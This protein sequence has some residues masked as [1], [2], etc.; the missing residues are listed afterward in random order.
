MPSLPLP[1]GPSALTGGV[2]PVTGSADVL[3]EFPRPQ[4][5]A[6]VAPVR[7]A[8]VAAFAAGFVK[9]QN[10]ASRAALQSDPMMATGNY[11]KSFAD[12]HGVIPGV[13]E[14]EAS[15]RSR[16]FTAPEVVTPEFI[17]AGVNALI[18][19]HSPIGCHLSELELD[20]WFVH[21]G[22]SE[23]DSFIG[24][25]PDY[26]DR[27]YEDLPYLTPGGAVPSWGYIRSFLL[28]VPP[29]EGSDDDFTFMLEDEDGV[30]VNNGTDIF[31]S[32]SDGSVAFSIY[33]NP[34]TSD[35]IYKSIVGY[36]ERVKGQG[37]SWSLLADPFL[38]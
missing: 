5:N 13:D 28:R 8:F 6:D 11:L 24:E 17:V 33:E 18:A 3:A 27:Y 21:D 23:W 25:E 15:V 16:L 2:L 32:E 31:G 4:R 7:D 20:G 9:Y 14:T 22:T 29:L 19:P 37:I 1:L 12:E 26:P 34:L 10:E 36:V 30:F 35:E 38:T